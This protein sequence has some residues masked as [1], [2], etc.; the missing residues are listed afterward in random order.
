MR[1][2]PPSL[3]DAA[4]LAARLHGNYR[5]IQW[6]NFFWMFLVVMPVVV[7]IWQSHGFDMHQ[8]YLLQTIFA[9]AVV[10]LEVPSGYLAD[11]LGR[12]TSLVLGGALA[13]AAF[14]WFAFA[15][16]FWEF[17]VFELL[18]AVGASLYSGSDVAL[19]YDTDDELRRLSRDPLLPAARGER[20]RVA[21]ASLGRRL[22]YA[23]TGETLAAI[24]GGLLVLVSLDLPAKVNAVTSWGA[25]V[26]A[27]G[28]VEPSR[29]TVSSERSHLQKLGAIARLLFRESRLL[30]L[31]LANLVVYGLATLTAVWAFQGYWKAEQVPLAFFGWLWAAY[32]LTV[33][34]VGRIAHS[35]EARFG[36]A[37]I[38]LSIG[39][40][41]VLGFFGMAWGGALAGILFGFA[42]QVSRGL[43]QVVLKDALNS[44]V[45]TDYRATANSVSTLGVRFGFAMIGPLMGWMID[46]RGY[47]FAFVAFGSLYVA[48]FFLVCIPLVAMR[49]SYRGTG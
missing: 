40:L 26:V 1:T 38:V 13:G 23:Q 31:V 14:T 19:I 11:H 29:E 16:R 5:R 36:S 39:L 10:I 30:T 32:N 22:F 42:F 44:R 27:L 37:A 43:T 9:L 3:I 49:R 21:I 35:L 46:R 15:D 7:P 34:L 25:F 24:L 33:A 4:S 41:P 48:L 17:V 8:V 18:A 20:D 6:I 12:K 45:P 47:S 28:L 2:V